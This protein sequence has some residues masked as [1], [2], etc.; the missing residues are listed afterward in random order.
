MQD[1]LLFVS[2]EV[3]HKHPVAKGDAEPL[4]LDVFLQMPDF[5]ANAIGVHVALALDRVGRRRVHVARVP[6]HGARNHAQ[7]GV[8]DV[9]VLRRQIFRARW[10]RSERIQLNGQMSIITNGLLQRCGRG[11][12]GQQRKIDTRRR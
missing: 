7:I 9:V 8:G 1:G 11:H 12:L 4:A 10:W 6:Q 5:V 3:P 2:G